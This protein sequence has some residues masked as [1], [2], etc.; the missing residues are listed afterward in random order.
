MSRQENS[1]KIQTKIRKIQPHL[2]PSG[3]S[4]VSEDTETS[5]KRGKPVPGKQQNEAIEQVS[6]PTVP[7]FVVPVAPR[8]KDGGADEDIPAGASEQSKETSVNVAAKDKDYYLV[9]HL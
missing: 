6:Q 5:F 7:V 2:E 9:E 1:P 8:A 4:E 3:S